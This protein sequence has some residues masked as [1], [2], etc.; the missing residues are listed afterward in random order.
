MAAN[1]SSIEVG[2]LEDL[3]S[4]LSALALASAEALAKE[5]LDVAFE[6]PFVDFGKHNHFLFRQL[7]DIFQFYLPMADKFVAAIVSGFW[8]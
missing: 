3:P 1:N 2:F 6:D 8:G 7:A 5:G 4:D